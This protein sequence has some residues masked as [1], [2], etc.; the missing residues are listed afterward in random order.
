[1]LRPSLLCALA[2]LCGCTGDSSVVEIL[3]RREAAAA[4]AFG[5]PLAAIP[6]GTED[7][8]VAGDVKIYEGEEPVD[9]IAA[10]CVEAQ[11]E[12]WF[13]KAI[14]E[15]VCAG[16]DFEALPP[17]ARKR[18]VFF[19]SEISVPDDPEGR[20]YPGKLV[21]MEDEAPAASVELFLAA[22]EKEI[23]KNRTKWD[24][25]HEAWEKNRTKNAAF[26]VEHAGV[27]RKKDDRDQALREIDELDWLLDNHTLSE[28]MRPP[29]GWFRTALLE[30]VCGLP[31]LSCG[32]RRKPLPE[33]PITVDGSGKPRGVVRPYE[34]DEG[35]DLAYLF[36]KQHDLT[37]DVFRESLMSYLCTVEGVSCTRTRAKVFSRSPADIFGDPD[38]RFWINFE[39][40]EDEE[41]VDAAFDYA[42]RFQLTL[43]QRYALLQA[44]CDDGY[45]D[46]ARPASE[47]APRGVHR[48][49]PRA[50]ERGD[51]IAF[52]FAVTEGAEKKGSIE[53]LSYQQPADA[54]Y[55][56]CRKEKYLQPKYTRLHVRANLHASFCAALEL[57]RGFLTDEER[58]SCDGRRRKPRVAVGLR[59]SVDGGTSDLFL[60]ILSS[61]SF[62]RDRMPA[63]A[64]AARRSRARSGSSRSSPSAD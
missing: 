49:V 6:I 34:G 14:T 47:R 45:V 11:L 22:A 28:P 55:D 25:Q 44:A 1:M 36:G 64:T 57:D 63:Q 15:R 54:V 59:R 16:G 33:L 58:A 40:W 24:K 50:G 56:Y 37:T 27:A 9:A 4:G 48:A 52:K 7:G 41:P 31:G 38:M 2:M 60:A 17:C 62:P 53:L 32:G 3:Q 19:A 12:P 42:R 39:I 18:A 43:E 21:V 20:T 10:F 35:V 30:H 13:R 26:A 5:E 29:A 51:P 61:R 8:G 46:C 23:N